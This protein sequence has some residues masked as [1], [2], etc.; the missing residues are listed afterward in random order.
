MI[1]HLFDNPCQYFPPISQFKIHHI[2]FLPFQSLNI[3]DIKYLVTQLICIIIHFSCYCFIHSKSH[4]LSSM[5]I[6]YYYLSIQYSWMCANT[7]SN[8]ISHFFLIYVRIIIWI[9]SEKPNLIRSEMTLYSFSI[10]FR[11]N[12]EFLPINYIFNLIRSLFSSK[13]RFYWVK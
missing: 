2:T 1:F 7:L 10:I 5:F 12:Y 3:E 8:Y 13:H 6:H 11:F 9:S 4:R